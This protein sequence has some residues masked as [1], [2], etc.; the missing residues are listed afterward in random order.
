MRSLSEKFLT[1]LA[2]K[3]ILFP[4]PLPRFRAAP[5]PHYLQEWVAS[6]ITPMARE[7]A[8]QIVAHLNYI[9]YE[10]FLSQLQ[11]SIDHFQHMIQNQPYFLMIGANIRY[12][13][14]EG[15]SDLW[16]IGLAL[17]YCGLQEPVE[18]IWSNELAYYA[19]K[20]PTVTT[21]LTLDDA[22]YSFDQ[23][24]RMFRES[25]ERCTLAQKFNLYVGIPFITHYAR[26]KLEKEVT[27]FHE[28]VLLDHQMIPV[29]TEIL[30]AKAL[31]FS[32]AMQVN[33]IDERHSLTYFDHRFADAFSNF[34]QVYEGTE[35]LGRIH[36]PVIMNFL[37][38][39]Y[40]QN[41]VKINAYLKLELNSE[42]YN[43]KVETLLVPNRRQN[44]QG[45]SIP[46]VISPYKLPNEIKAM[47]G[48]IAQGK[49]G[50]LTPYVHPTPEVEDLVCQRNI[51][52]GKFFQFK[53]TA[54]PL[55][56]QIAFDRAVFFS[57]DRYTTYEELSKYQAIHHEMRTEL[58][59]D[60][61]KLTPVS[62]LRALSISSSTDLND[63]ND[64]NQCLE[65]FPLCIIS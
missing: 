16:I 46:M 30:D 57:N 60:R 43:I 36:I 34:Q 32:D 13:L 3:N 25:F 37:G 35:I 21:I 9:S 22:A 47:Q 50:E 6:Q 40:Q 8:A 11:K 31:F 62:H 44:A 59:D 33:F 42:I 27:I 15:C 26:S 4:T 39:T 52:Q 56:K 23:K 1:S 38:I 58:I 63:S 28:I 64:S 19:Q 49:I 65:I 14:D 51:Y 53:K 41:L 2:Q 29:V 12:F 54:L 20:H 18:L 7:V 24:G 5:N 45:Y 55:E 10:T 48:Y 61:P 17:E